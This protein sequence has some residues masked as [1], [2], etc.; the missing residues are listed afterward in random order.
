MAEFVYNNINNTST[1][2]TP[3]ELNCGFHCQ[4]SYKKDVDPQS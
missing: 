3:F 2:D 4:A 1:D